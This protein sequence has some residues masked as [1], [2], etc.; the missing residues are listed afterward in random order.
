M[1]SDGPRAIRLLAVASKGGHWEQLMLLRPAFE[2][3][4]VSFATTD[5]GLASRDGI[6]D[7]LI[8]PDA[9]RDRP[10]L[11]VRCIWRAWSI[12][13]ATRPD[14]VITTGA[15]PGLLCIIAARALGAKTIWVDSVANSERISASGRWARLF[16]TRWMTQWEHLAKP[17]GLIFDGRL[18]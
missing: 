7:A 2:G 14:C 8:L 10:L 4:L 9:N 1:K 11:T 12:V 18:L 6:V 3:F 5:A 16:A 15:L 17:P 13:R